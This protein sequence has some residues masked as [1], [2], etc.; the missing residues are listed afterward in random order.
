MLELG[1]KLGLGQGSTLVQEECRCSLE[2]VPRRGLER[3]LGQGGRLELERG[4]QCELERVLEQGGTLVLERGP[5]CE[6]EQVLGGRPVL[7]QG[8]TQVRGECRC[9]LEL[10]RVPRSAQGRERVPRSVRELALAGRLERVL[11]GRLGRVLDSCSPTD[12]KHRH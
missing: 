5:Q 10:E 12:G 8:S 7:E 4:L 11:A 1:G 9:S 6:L 2:Q 3:V